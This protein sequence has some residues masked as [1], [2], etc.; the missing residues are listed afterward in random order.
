MTP[1]DHTGDAAGPHTL[2]PDRTVLACGFAIT[3]LLSWAT[4]PWPQ[5]LAST[6]LGTLMVAGADVDARHFLL[7]DIVTGG[8]LLAGL[9]VAAALGSYDRWNGPTSALSG[10]FLVATALWLLRRTYQWLRRR[11]GI[12]LGDVKLA[13]AIGAWLPLDAV[14]LCFAL[15]STAALI[16]VLLARLRDQSIERTTKLP[17]GAFLCPALWL[18]DYGIRLQATWF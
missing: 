5:A 8:A 3:A 10:S 9:V 6:V 2:L 12:G 18:V 7:P 13:A 15:A 14:P 17:L 1:N 4:L 11:E 16:A